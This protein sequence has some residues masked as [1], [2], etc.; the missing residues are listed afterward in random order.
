VLT[1]SF[2]EVAEHLG[3]TPTVAKQ[4]YVDPRVVAAF[5][6][7]RTI[8]AAVRRAAERSAASRERTRDVVEPAVIRLLSRE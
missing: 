5:E 6:H 1:D 8:A 4:S 7:G 2:R 3:N